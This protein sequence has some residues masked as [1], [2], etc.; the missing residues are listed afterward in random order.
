MDLLELIRRANAG[1]AEARAQLLALGCHRD[2]SSGMSIRAQ[3]F[4]AETRTFNVTMTTEKA[5]PMPDWDRWEM[6]P[7][8]LRADGMEAPEQIPLLNAHSRGSIGD[9]LGSVR[10][11]KR[12]ADAVTGNARIAKTADGE[13]AAELIKSGDLTDVSV[14]YEVTAKT[15]IPE[16]TSQVIGGKAYDGP[17][18]VATKWRLKELSLVPIGADS[19]AK[20]RTAFNEFLIGKPCG[21]PVT[22][23][24]QE[25]GP[26]KLKLKD[27]RELTIAEVDALR[28]RGE[29][30]TLEDGTVLRSTK[31]TETAPA[32]NVVDVVK[33]R[34]EATKAEAERQ[35]AI[36]ELGAMAGAT[37]EEIAALIDGNK[38][39]LEASREFAKKYAA[40]RQAVPTQP[41]ATAGDNMSVKSLADSITGAILVRAGVAT[42]RGNMLFNGQPVKDKRNG[43]ELLKTELGPHS[44]RLAAFSLADMAR[45][46]VESA[47]IRTIG[48]TREEILT[49][50]F[51]RDQSRTAFNTTGNFTVALENALNKTLLPGFM[52]EDFTWADW[53]REVPIT[54]LRA[55]LL[56]KPSGFGGLARVNEAGEVP[57]VAMPDSKRESITAYQHGG[58]FNLT[59]AAIINDDMGF[60]NAIV[61]G[62]GRA[63][64]ETIESE[65]Y[66]TYLSN[67]TMN[68]TTGAMVNA[69]VVTTAGGHANLTTG[70]G[71]P[72]A[73]TYDALTQKMRLQKN[74]AG[75]AMNLR[76]D[77]VLTGPALEYTVSKLYRDTVLPG[78]NNNEMNM[79]SGLYR[80]VISALFQTG[81]TVRR[82]AGNLTVAGTSTRYALINR[83]YSPIAIGF[84]AGRVPTFRSERPIGQFGT[85]YEAQLDFGV[86]AIEWRGVQQH[87]GA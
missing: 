68:E 6:I 60:F 82:A 19:N 30:I 13:L 23:H 73:T 61:A 69:T 74:L 36:R 66:Y 49:I 20:I 43:G 63:G 32:A 86:A 22:S 7:E 8:V 9:I 1:D 18:N 76:P 25:A 51:G 53:V 85:V 27:G 26:M 71:A 58:T 42:D 16:K 47:G 80:P 50:A 39:E 12:E 38:S 62:M 29:D 28:A 59:D 31:A 33:E 2:G 75:W 4:N 52:G 70:A 84:R 56:Y 45:E 79:Y 41:R 54:D 83:Q 72:S 14:G 17:V 35:K 78:G 65:V 10:D 67:P 15:F 55:Q 3:S 64:G 81:V 44:L 11:F 24:K 40:T 48:L 34:A 21:H 87:N 37:A 77:V 46:F 5:V 57:A